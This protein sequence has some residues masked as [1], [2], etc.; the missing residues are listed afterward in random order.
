MTRAAFA[1]YKAI[2]ATSLGC[3]LS[4]S[5]KRVAKFNAFQTTERVSIFDSLLVATVAINESSK[6][7]TEIGSRD[8]LMSMIASHK[9]GIEKRPSVTI[10]IGR[11]RFIRATQRTMKTPRSRENVYRPQ[12]LKY[13][14]PSKLLSWILQPVR[15]FYVCTEDIF[16]LRS[17]TSSPVAVMQ[18]LSRLEIRQCLS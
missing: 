9:L 1:R 13:E 6:A 3:G 18:D 14:H 5:V 8:S 17:D 2:I 4:I 11:E 12:R 15:C 10:M 16:G 7:I